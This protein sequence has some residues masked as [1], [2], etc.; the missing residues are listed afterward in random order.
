MDSVITSGISSNI[1]D[2]VQFTGI[3]TISDAYYRI[4]DVP[5]EIV[6]LLQEL[7]VTHQFR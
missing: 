3:A 5:Q 6:F 7:E 2:T 1:G 4:T